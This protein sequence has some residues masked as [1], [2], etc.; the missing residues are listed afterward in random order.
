MKEI[1][2]KFDDETGNFDVVTPIPFT[3]N[4]GIEV[5]GMMVAD[6]PKYEDTETYNV[7]DLIRENQKLRIQ[8]SSRKEIANKYKEVI[9]KLRE[10]IGKHYF[11][12]SDDYYDYF[13]EGVCLQDGD[14]Q[15]L[16]DI[17]KEVE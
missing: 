4:D 5:L 6:I 17:L 10:L 15:E 11:K 7:F 1:I 2:T 13:T 14:Y 9:N 12:Q 8:A 3:L 16:E